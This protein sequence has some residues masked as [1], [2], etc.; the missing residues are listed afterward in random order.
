ML[1][2]VSNGG[3]RSAVRRNRLVSA[4][5]L[6]TLAATPF[7]EAI[8]GGTLFERDINMV[9]L[10]QVESLVRA[11]AN[12]SWP[13]WDPYVGFGQP[14]LADPRVGVLYPPTWLNLLLPP[15]V[16][17]TAFVV[18]H[19][20]GSGWGMLALARHW[21]ASRLAATFTATLW[22]L[23]GPLLSLVPMWHH[24]AGFAWMPWVALAASR[25]FERPARA[26]SVW[27]GCAVALQWLAGSPEASLLTLLVVAVLAFR[28]L[29][30][31]WTDV[32]LRRRLI[33]LTALGALIGSTL[34]AAQWLPTLDIVARS[35]RRQ[36]AAEDQTA[37]S[38]HPWAL[39]E[40]I[41][42]ARFGELPLD[43]EAI[44]RILD[45]RP[46]WLRSI[47]LGAPALGLVA[48]G[49]LGGPSG[50][51]ALAWLLGFS[52]I[53][54]MGRHVP[55]YETATAL[56]PPLQWL[57]YPV[58]ILL[59]AAFAW[60]LLAGRGLDVVSGSA[61][62]AR[63]WSRRV[64]LPASF[65]FLACGGVWWSLTW[66][67][68]WLR[69]WLLPLPGEVLA[70]ALQPS[71]VS[72][73]IATTAAA[74]ALALLA[75]RGPAG[76]GG[77]GLAVALA[78]VCAAD[79]LHKH[80][81][82]NPVAPAELFDSRPRVLDSLDLGIADRLFVRDYSIAAPQESRS[83]D[84]R[85]PYQLARL[86]VG[87]PPQAGLVLGVHEY[88]NPPTAA[89]W[90]L[91]GS[92]DFDILGLQ[93]SY[94]HA[95]TE[96][97]RSLEG[98]PEAHTRLL[99]MGGVTHALGLREAGWWKGLEPVTETPGWFAEPV[100]VFRVPEPLTRAYAVRGAR[101]AGDE[102]ALELLASPG[103]DPAQELI[104]PSG[105]PRERGP[106]PGSVRVLGAEHGEVRLHASLDAPGFL[107]L[108]DAFD[109]GWRATVDGRPAR[110]LR[111]NIALRAVE[112]GRGRHHVVFEYR[113]RWV[114]W[115]LA[116]S[117]FGLA[118]SFVALAW[119]RRPDSA[120]SLS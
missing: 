60:S 2:G 99:R 89:R 81:A 114:S 69:P 108:A 50:G 26:R 25:A 116:I 17:Y 13:L 100:R 55:L 67:S 42:P 3:A 22:M 40:L 51:R 43:P 53:L 52:V 120:Q 80:V 37:W 64:V 97:L 54:S 110:I 47:Y 103:F 41:A 8:L 84:L 19:V 45:D 101:I 48:A 30:S 15:T 76:R 96:R 34:P 77:Q 61:P 1:P 109:P 113:P 49:L 106:A 119:G 85:S 4:A 9:W 6:A 73:A 32:G 66:G 12:G 39:T 59:V 63:G 87:W 68:A 111:A 118:T 11:V 46:P 74:V 57:R 98:D 115:G 14:M 70:Q 16:F 107:V 117:L 29:R 5:V 65:S 27:L 58:K 33:R 71:I 83:P 75:W 20:A 62:T 28:A 23:S 82:L 93:P 78:L 21:S 92:F 112:L 24:L 95:L 7:W 56:L 104:L 91:L 72:A 90:G 44:H 36:Q 10:P 18:A 102:R 79:L 94:Q 35:S 88:L 105:R 31:R 38:R 86:P